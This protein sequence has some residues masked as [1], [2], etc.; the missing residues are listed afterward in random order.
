MTDRLL[1]DL[2]CLSK[3]F[4][5]LCSIVDLYIY[6]VKLSVI[7]YLYYYLLLFVVLPDTGAPAV[8]LISEEI[9]FIFGTVIRVTESIL[10]VL[11][12]NTLYLVGETPVN[13]YYV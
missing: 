13:K 5:W 12:K 11:S 10:F 2:Y 3:T 6:R 7:D 4:Y 9:L 1:L 8:I